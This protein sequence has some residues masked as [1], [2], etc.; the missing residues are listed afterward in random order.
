MVLHS[1]WIDVV[2]GW[3]GFVES[4]PRLEISGETIGLDEPIHLRARNGAEAGS[5]RNVAGPRTLALLRG[6]LQDRK[7]ISVDL[8]VVAIKEQR[9]LVP[10]QRGG[11]VWLGQRK[12]GHSAQRKS[13]RQ[14]PE[15]I[16][17]AVHARRSED[18]VLD[19]WRRLNGPPSRVSRADGGAGARER[20]PDHVL[21]TPCGVLE[22]TRR[23]EFIDYKTS[24]TTC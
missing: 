23:R 4:S 3:W 15:R 7:T 16:P 18:I 2:V 24:L 17:T 1:D 9:V 8:V 5:P 10:L 11:P 22:A 14:A 12:R 6:R 19:S 21:R 20:G 13:R